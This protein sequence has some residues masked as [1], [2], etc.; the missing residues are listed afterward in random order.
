MPKFRKDLADLRLRVAEAQMEAMGVKVDAYRKQVGQLAQQFDALADRTAAEMAKDIKSRSL[1][2]DTALKAMTAFYKAEKDFAASLTTMGSLWPFFCRWVADD[3]S[4]V[5]PKAGLTKFEK[6]ADPPPGAVVVAE[7]VSDSEGRL[8]VDVKGV[9]PETTA[10]ASASAT[11]KYVFTPNKST[12]Y[13][14]RPNVL[15]NGWYLMWSWGTC[16]GGV[17]SD[18]RAKVTLRVRVDQFSE[19]KAE[20]EI[21]VLDVTSG[22]GGVEFPVAGADILAVSAALEAGHDAVVVVEC[23]VTAEVTGYGR[24]IVD[25]ASTSGSYIKAPTVEATYMTCKLPLKPPPV[26]GPWP[27][28]PIGPWPPKD[29]VERPEIDVIKPTRPGR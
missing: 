1:R 23:E 21:V 13:M 29:I 15:L 4:P 8:K 2:H 5:P 10:S 11:F 26:I 14:I 19:T 20:D 27:W 18:G 25:L 7:K 6:S 3:E 12:S 17:T 22:E 16:A 9:A 28:P 24:A